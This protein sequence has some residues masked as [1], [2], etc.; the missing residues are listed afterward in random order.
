VRDN[1]PNWVYPI[2]HRTGSAAPNIP[3]GNFQTPPQQVASVQ[4][5]SGGLL[6][7][8]QA[9]G[10][11]LLG[12]AG[13][14]AK[15]GGPSPMPISTGSVVGRALQA[16][17]ADYSKAQ[18]EQAAIERQNRLR[19]EYGIIA[20][21]PPAVF[22][23]AMKPEAPFGT[24]TTGRMW[25]YYSA[26]PDHPKYKMATA[27]LSRPHYTQTAA[28]TM[29]T[30]AAMDSKGKLVSQAAQKAGVIPGTDPG[31][32]EEAKKI[33]QANVKRIRGF[34]KVRDAFR[35]FTR[36]Q[37]TV[38]KTVDQALSQAD[39]LFVGGK[40]SWLLEEIPGT[41]AYDFAQTLT[42]IKANICF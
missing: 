16:F 37:D 27:Y 7:N 11:G 23:A 30:P 34:P 9:L 6:G 8:Q 39:G 20:D 35:A 28:G 4:P 31:S 5:P 26:G 40:A 36:N 15:A 41:D 13:Q 24:S 17:A 2:G 21:A 25:Q 19:K 18:K 29:V 12:A 38:I 33:A 22:A 10:A 42:T 3:I 1:S 14:F 32:V